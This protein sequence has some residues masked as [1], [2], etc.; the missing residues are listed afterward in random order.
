MLGG[1]TESI[2]K[3]S[4]CDDS[5]IELPVEKHGKMADVNKKHFSLAFPFKKSKN[6]CAF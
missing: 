3:V 1:A 4:S 2:D 5:S 6:R